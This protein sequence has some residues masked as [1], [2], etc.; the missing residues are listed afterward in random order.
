MIRKLYLI[1]VCQVR[2]IH[3]TFTLELYSNSSKFEHV[4]RLFK[5]FDVRTCSN[6][7]LKCSN[8]ELFEHIFLSIFSLFFTEL[9]NTIR[10]QKSF[11]NRLTFSVD[12]RIQLFFTVYGNRLTFCVGPR[13]NI[14]R[15]LL[16]ENTDIFCNFLLSIA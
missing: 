3:Y 7:L 14:I 1:I 8:F 10:R 6:T 2:Q 16:F 13:L 4:R 12:C 11:S 15:N 5:N 9:S